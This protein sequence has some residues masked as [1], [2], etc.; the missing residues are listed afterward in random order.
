LEVK[1][2]LDTNAYSNFMRGESDVVA[3]VSAADE[4]YL[5]FVV[6][7]ELRA[8]FQV[9]SKRKANES[10][11]ERFLARQDVQVLYADAQTTSRY[12]ELY[13]YLRKKGKMIPENDLW[14]ASLVVQHQM[15][16]STR[17]RHFD[18]LPQVS[19]V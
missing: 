12:A 16:F 10:V 3:A 6:L 8:G 4:I 11:L 17:D 7:G 5:P 14:I 18:Q 15:R 2:A 9:G 19:K 1:L 13:S